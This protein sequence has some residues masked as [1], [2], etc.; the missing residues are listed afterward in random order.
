MSARQFE[1]AFRLPYSMDPTGARKTSKVEAEDEDDAEAIIRGRWT[2][3]R[4]REPEII[5]C[6]EVTE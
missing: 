3:S 5:G 2:D 6:Y 1:I 4:G